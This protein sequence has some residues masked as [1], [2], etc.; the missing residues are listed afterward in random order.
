MLA[1]LGTAAYAQSDTGLYL[2]EIDVVGGEA[3]IL[4]ESSLAIDL[5]A[6]DP[7]RLVQAL[8]ETTVSIQS[9]GVHGIRVTLN[10]D[11]HFT[12]QPD[13]RL[14]SSTWVVDFDQPPVQSLLQDLRAASLKGEVVQPSDVTRF[15]YEQIGD[16]HYRTGFDIASQVA[17][18]LEGDCTEHAVLNAALMRANGFSARVVLGVII[19]LNEQGAT[20]AGHAWN[21]IYHDGGWHIHDATLPM[22]DPDV[23]RVFYLPLSSLSD[24]GPGYAM[25]LLEFAFLR[26]TKI[27]LLE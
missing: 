22:E 3:G 15:T 2:Y 12:G 24:E 27:H 7:G 1:S 5:L 19:V 11:D 26:P 17:D 14:T 4:A 21:E 20:A 16:K 6:Q 9:A 23:R 18:S 25:E 8:G 10:G 13:A